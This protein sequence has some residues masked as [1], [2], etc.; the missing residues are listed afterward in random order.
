MQDDQSGNLVAKASI[1]YSWRSENNQTE[2]KFNESNLN[3]M[4]SEKEQQHVTITNRNGTTMEIEQQL[5]F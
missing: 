3:K 2:R 1:I 4:Q 5:Q